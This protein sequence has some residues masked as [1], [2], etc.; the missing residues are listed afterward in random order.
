[1]PE[2][3]G[4]MYELLKN[5]FGLIVEY[6]NEI[7]SLRDDFSKMGL[8][9]VVKDHSKEKIFQID[10]NSLNFTEGMK[11][12]LF[13]I[14]DY[15]QGMIRWH[16]FFAGLV[17]VFG[18]INWFKVLRRKIKI[19]DALNL[20][21]IDFNLFKFQVNHTI[22]FIFPP[23][24]EFFSRLCHKSETIPKEFTP[25]YSPNTL[26]FIEIS[27]KL[28]S[29]WLKI[30]DEIVQC[31]PLVSDEKGLPKSFEMVLKLINRM[32]LFSDTYYSKVE[33]FLKFNEERWENFY[34]ED[35]WE[36]SDL[37]NGI[38]EKLIETFRF[39]TKSYE[40]IS[41]CYLSVLATIWGNQDFA[42]I[43]LSELLDSEKK[44]DEIIPIKTPYENLNF[45]LMQARTDLEAS[46]QSYERFK[47][48]L[49]VFKVLDGVLKG[50]N[51]DNL[52]EGMSS[53]LEIQEKYWH[54]ILENIINLQKELNSN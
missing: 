9:K 42:Q 28:A 31:I 27:G 37:F 1:M 32:I 21:K 20:Y 40:Y 38:R 24:E 11:F 50:S 18:E 14:D 36:L 49:E 5:F 45:G 3:V 52:Y 10:Q 26:E 30:H 41:K 47:E 6:H 2:N 39:R 13:Y 48:N 23:I 8:S 7:T 22:T 17:H 51:M 33:D 35:L 12:I 4:R 44:I 25:I 46:M 54:R 43:K 29:E 34:L 19:E 16:E 53:R 15:I